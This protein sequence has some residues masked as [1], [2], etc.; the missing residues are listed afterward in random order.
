[1]DEVSDNEPLTEAAGD[2]LQIVT[3]MR[4]QLRHVDLDEAST[5]ERTNVR[6]RIDTLGDVLVVLHQTLADIET[7]AV[8]LA[9]LGTTPAQARERL[10]MAAEGRR[11]E[12][13]DAA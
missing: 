8:V 9:L 3:A 6:A 4:D 12:L 1:M 2:L 10:A 5:F 11:L 13:S 7:Q